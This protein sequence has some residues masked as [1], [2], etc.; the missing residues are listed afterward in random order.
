MIKLYFKHFK[1]YDWLCTAFIVGLTFLEVWCMMELTDQS[2]ALLTAIGYAQ[3]NGTDPIWE[4]ALWMVAYA[5]FY[6]LAQAA[7]AVLASGI[8]ANFSRSVRKAVNDKITYMSM[9][10]IRKFQTSSLITR[11]TNDI[12]TIH[13]TTVLGLRMVFS[14]P[15]TAVWAFIKIGNV[16]W[17]LAYV[18]GIGILVLVAGLAAIMLFVVPKFKVQQKLL[19]RV[20]MVTRGNL[21]GIRVVRAYNAE[22]YQNGKF[23]GANNDLTKVSL[24]TGRMLN[25]INPI[26]TIVMNGIILGIYWLGATLVGNSTLDYASLTA[27]MMLSIQIVMAFMMLLFMFIMIPRSI[28]CAKRVNEVLACEDKIKDPEVEEPFT[29]EGTIEFDDVTFQYPDAES[30]VIEHISFKANKGQTVAFIGMTGSGKSSTVNLVNRLYDV[31]SGAIKLNGVDVRNMKKKTLRKLIGFVPQKA[32]LFSG[33]VNSNIR[34]GNESLDQEGVERAARIACADSFVSEMEGG[35]EAHIAQ[36]G[37]NVSGGQR[38]R[39]CIARAV[40]MDP[41]FYVF[42]DS[43]SALDFKTDKTVRENL[44]TECSGATKLIVAQR[45]GTIMDA[46]VIIVLHEGK[47]VGRGKHEE[48]LQTCPEYREIALSQLS[49]EEL[50]L[51]Q[52]Q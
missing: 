29:E 16:S 24:F 26:I 43:F 8:G 39:L 37:S 33:T 9:E 4:A 31:T 46:D 38:Q 15:I 41:S 35:Y 36:G 3:L 30:P 44:K 34:F 49:K 20:N 1:W 47:M 21:T 48:L 13:F 45:V 23:E 10:D 2:E 50:G 5:A 40:A 52:D 42:D 6:M 19:D 32:V 18:P 7:A 14:A 22:D 12:Q 28:V 27:F 51:C 25:A 11:V 17:D